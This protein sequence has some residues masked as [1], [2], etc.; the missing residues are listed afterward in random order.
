MILRVMFIRQTQTRSNGSGES[1]FTYRL[2]ESKRVGRKVSQHTLLNLGIHFDLST[3]VWPELCT[4]IEQILSSEQPLFA[5][6]PT[7]ETTA[8]HIYNQIIA[9]RGEIQSLGDAET[10][11]ANPRTS[12]LQRPPASRGTC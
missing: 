8:Q 2:V 4:R 6:D 5:S 9:R 10:N 1:Y 3:E 12:R 7:I 11:P